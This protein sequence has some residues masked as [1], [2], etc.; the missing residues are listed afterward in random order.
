M[1][2]R[3]LILVMLALLV[4][5][6]IAAALIP[7]ERDRLSP[8]ETTTTPAAEPTVPAGTFVHRRVSAEAPKPARIRLEVGDQLDL[9]VTAKRAGQ[10]EIQAFGEFDDVDPDFPARFDLLAL[11]PG[12][13]AVRLVDRRTIA[14]IEVTE[15]DQTGD[16]SSND[17]PG[18]SRAGSTSGASSAS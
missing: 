1:A 15:P 9:V 7:V 12:D 17:E 14:R 13:F 5:S 6:S 10:V 11:E 16:A 18:S 2:A 3:R 4:L 8:R